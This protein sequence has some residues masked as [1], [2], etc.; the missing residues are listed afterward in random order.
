M[1]TKLPTPPGTGSRVLSIPRNAR[2]SITF[3]N[4]GKVF[5]AKVIRSTTYAEWDAAIEASLYRWSAEGEAIDNAKPHVT[6]EWNYLLND[7]FGED[8]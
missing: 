2:V 8:E 4:K 1:T 3:D 5:E 6:I 7:L